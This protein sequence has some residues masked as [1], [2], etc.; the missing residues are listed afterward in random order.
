MIPLIGPLPFKVTC[1]ASSAFLLTMSV[2]HSAGGMPPHM[3]PPGFPA[4]PF[5]MWGSYAPA[6]QQQ[7]GV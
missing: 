3:V 4:V 6:A 1:D 2:M 7:V 5:G